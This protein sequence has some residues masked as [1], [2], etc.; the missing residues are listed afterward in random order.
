MW[1]WRDGTTRR[2]SVPDR[3]V[4]DAVA[5]GGTGEA[6]R[7]A[8]PDVRAA[9]PGTVVALPVPDGTRVEAGTT[10]VVVE[11]MKMEHPL[12]APHPGTLRLHVRPGDLARLGQVVAVV[13]PDTP[14]ATPDPDDG[15][16]PAAVVH[17]APTGADTPGG[18]R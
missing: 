9:M 14:D 3:A 6:G 17:P 12:T 2:W 13:E 7:T 8:D 1:V 10:V 11:A 4:R 5:A 18:P 15:P 16:T